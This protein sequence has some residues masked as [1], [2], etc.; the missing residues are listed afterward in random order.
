MLAA[1]VAALALICL[2]V[3]FLPIAFPRLLVSRYLPRPKLGLDIQGGAR[4]V[5]EAQIDKLPAGKKWDADAKSAVFQTLEN[6][7]NANGVSEPVILPKGD[8]QFIVELP[9]ISN[10]T[11]LLDQLQNTAQLEFYYSPDWQTNRNTYGRYQLRSEGGTNGRREEYLIHDKQTNVDFRDRFHINQALKEMADRGKTS[12]AETPLPAPLTDLATAAGR[13]TLPLTPEDATALPA[14]ADELKNF[15]AFLGAAKLQMTGSD[16]LPGG[17]HSGFAQSGTTQ[18]IVELEFNG[19]GTRKFG[20]FTKDHS[21]EILMIFLDGRILMTPNINE[22]IL[23]GKAQI[24]PFASVKEAKQLADYLN[25]G[26][27]PVPLKIVQQQSVEA[28]LGKEAVRAGL[29]A[30]LVGIAGVILYVI[31]LYRLP[32]AVACCALL[33]YTLFTYTIFLLVPV[34]F[35]LPGI[36]GFIL[37]VGMAIDANILIFERTK[38]ELKEGKTLIRAVENGFSR[39]FSAIFDSNLCTAVTS[40]LL[41]NF[42]TGPVRGFA[43]TL[44]IGV[45]VSMFTAITVT[46]SFL[47]LMVEGGTKVSGMARAFEAWGATALW[48]PQMYTVQRRVL[49][50]LLSVAVIV[51]GMIALFGGGFKPG[52]EFTGGSE[53][54]LQFSQPV[55]REAVEKAMKEA[56]GA[57]TA[58]AAA[59]IAG[60]NT[61]IVRLPKRVGQ[62]ELTQADAQVLVAKIAAAFP[63]QKVTQEEF[64]LIGGSISKEL[65]TNALYSIGLSSLFIVTYLTLRFAVGGFRNGIKF[66]VA[67]IIAMLHDVLVL[68]GVF[69]ILGYFLNWKVDSLFVTAALT[70]IGFSVHDTIII[71]DRIRENLKLRGGRVEFGELVN[72]SIN[73]TFARSVNTSMTVIITLTALLILGGA[74]IRPLNAALLIGI[75]SGTYSSIFNAAQ[76]V[77]D[78]QRLFGKKGG[79]YSSATERLAAP[80]PSAL[81]KLKPGAASGT[82]AKAYGTPDT[83]AKT[84]SAPPLTPTPSPASQA[85][86]APDMLPPTPPTSRPQLPTAPA[87]RKRRM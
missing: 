13:A 11:Q 49:F 77:V 26:S 76:I 71:F 51:P 75:V 12:G 6:R 70:V 62:P 38:E 57:Q 68:G 69:A 39:A 61:V 25:G 48:R 18:A 45:A 9:G 29:V 56:G 53:I 84:Y 47:L 58:D 5:L 74:V 83:G 63:N 3:I 20:N 66:G 44:L 14:L 46:R 78:W 31:A 28:T 81:D 73:E 55:A 1:I 86:R 79:V 64:S 65:T 30:G 21:Q 32:G 4:V 43:M 15:E 8:K 52:I 10:Q 67:A 42:G 33:L 50:Y 24:S 34:T 54:T 16:L 2:F 80:K 27:L 37:S 72:E 35:T 22:P 19:E 23:S 40:L 82:G 59:Q 85:D 87:K 36:A 41:Y 60:N 7:V 17:A